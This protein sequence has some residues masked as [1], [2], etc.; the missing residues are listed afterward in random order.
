MRNVHVREFAA[1]PRAVG[2]ILETLASSHDEWWVTRLVE[3][4]LMSDGILV[5]SRGGHG[6]VLYEVVD[7]DPGKSATFRFSPK[8]AD[9]IHEFRVARGSAPGTTRVTHTIEAR[10]RGTMLWGWPLFI[11]VAHDAV[12]EDIFDNLERRFTGSANRRQKDLPAWL[13]RFAERHA[14]PSLRNAVAECPSFRVLW[15]SG[16]PAHQR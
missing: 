13:R 12:I 15:R 11:R 1:D 6:S 14:A 2:A 10:L 8:L 16:H 4:M 9:G 3:P 7:H 5:G